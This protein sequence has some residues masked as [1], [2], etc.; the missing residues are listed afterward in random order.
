[1][2]KRMQ[3]RLYIILIINALIRPSLAIDPATTIDL[4][5]RWRFKIGD[6]KEYA[7]A[8]YNDQQWET[9]EVPSRW[10]DAGFPGYDGYAWYRKTVIVPSAWQGKAIYLKIGR[11]DDVDQVFLNGHFVSANG[12]FPPAFRTAFDLRREYALPQQW[13]KWNQENVIA[14]RVFD[15]KSSG[16]IVEGPVNISACGEPL[17]LEIDLA[18]EWAFAVGDDLKRKNQDYDDRAWKKI[19]VPS[20]WEMQGF[21]DYDGVAWYRKTII[22]PN[23]LAEQPLLLVL[24]YINDMDEVFW[25]GELVGRT[26]RFPSRDHSVHLNSSKLIARAYAIAPDLVRPNVKITIAVRVYDF[27]RWGGIYKGFIGITTAESWLKYDR[28]K[29]DLP[30]TSRDF[31]F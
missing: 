5:G 10:E 6:Q 26:G 30:A 2:H 3:Q 13:L 23:E 9:V 22:L 11:I 25:N 28:Q 16:G 12:L 29:P 20:Y 31:N 8:Y 14:V 18:G 15:E 17:K 24:G 21:P 1:M 27:G 4:T 7:Q 19:L